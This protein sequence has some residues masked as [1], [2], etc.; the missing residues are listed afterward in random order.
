M[1][2]FRGFLVD[3]AGVMHDLG[4]LGGPTAIA[5]DISNSGRIVG[6]SRIADGRNRAFLY[7][8]GTMT[9][10]PSLGGIFDEATGINERAWMVGS[11][12]YPGQ[13]NARRA[14]LWRNGGIEDLGTL[15][16]AT[17][18][19]WRI[20]ER[21]DVVGQARTGDG[22]THAFLWRDGVMSDLGT[23]GGPTSVGLALNDAGVVV[24]LSE[25]G[26]IDPLFGPICPRLP[27]GGRRDR[28]SR[29]AVLGGSVVG[30]CRS[31]KG[32]PIMRCITVLLAIAMATALTAAAAEPAPA[33]GADE[34]VVTST[35]QAAVDA[36]Q[37][38]DT[39]VVPPGRYHES[40]TITK[41]GIT[42]RGSRGA[43]LDASGFSTGIR[44]AS[45]PGGPVC[46]PLALHDLAVE[47]LSIE[48][49]SFT[50]VFFRGVDGFA[51]R[52]GSYSGNRS[53]RDLPGL[54]PRRCDQWQSRPGHERRRHL[55]RQLRPRRSRAEPC[56]RLDRRN[57]SRELHGHL[58]SG[59]QDD[60]QYRRH[61]GA[62]VLP[63]L[64]VPVTQDVLIERNVVM[65]N[66]RPNPIAPSLEDPISL[67]PTG[68]GI[69]TVGADRV[70]M[71]DNRVVG[72]DTGGIGLIALPLSK[73]RSAGRSR[74]RRRRGAQQHRAWQRPPSRCVALAATGG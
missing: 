34:V 60:R 69:L 49:A 43:V 39:V 30:V 40:V 68:T 4:T 23:L 14:V 3:R 46:P 70:V 56:D 10:L 57:P 12:F 13:P 45:G 51:I 67:L 8:Q 35:I 71:R 36:A 20:N 47:G 74:A 16:G 24:G 61:R 72:N 25:T 31:M 55:R 29:T 59:E 33:A 19:A 52:N 27:L 48:G 50:G 66:N 17:A 15:G 42:I 5:R 1:P 9:E 22:V 44:A 2:N 26:V 73:P 54:L 38:G 63:G 41:S 62:F 32:A 37:P 64:A 18:R 6:G 11:A 58:R 28:G 7:D 21:G 65:Q 53:V